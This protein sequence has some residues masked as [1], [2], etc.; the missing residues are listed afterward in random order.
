M[1]VRPGT[2]QGWATV[3]G[4]AEDQLVIEIGTGAVLNANLDV[5]I[6]IV[7]RLSVC[8]VGMSGLRRVRSEARIKAIHHLHPAEFGR[9]LHRPTAGAPTAS[10]HRLGD[11]FDRAGR[12]W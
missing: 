10:K 9:S 5:G 8:C 7:H 4:T 12:L 2:F 3:N 11:Q 6:G 1:S